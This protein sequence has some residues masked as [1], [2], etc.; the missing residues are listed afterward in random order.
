ML[1]ELDGTTFIFHNGLHVHLDDLVVPVLVGFP[2]LRFGLDDWNLTSLANVTFRPLGALASKTDPDASSSVE[3]SESASL[4]IE[5]HS[6]SS[7]VMY[8]DLFQIAGANG[9]Q[10][11]HT[12]IAGAA[13][14]AF[15]FGV[16]FAVALGSAFGL[17]SAL[18]FARASALAALAAGVAAA[19]CLNGQ[20]S[21]ALFPVFLQA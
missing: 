19:S 8:E 10:A 16:F 18:G 9:F 5:E 2:G 12:R 1:C 6:D 3:Q 4:S 13:G 14:L 7:S 21:G 15:D 11:R 20:F 17:A